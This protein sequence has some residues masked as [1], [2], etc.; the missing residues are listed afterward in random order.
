MLDDEQALAGIYALQPA[1]QAGLEHAR[2]VERLRHL[3]WNGCGAEAGYG[4]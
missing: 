1:Y 3:I 4:C 2:D